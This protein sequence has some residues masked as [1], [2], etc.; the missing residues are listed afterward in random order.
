MDRIRRICLAGAVLALAATAIGAPVSALTI[1]P[2]LAIVQ[3]FPGS[4]VDI[5]LNGKEVR[6]RMRYGKKLLL[7]PN[8][9]TYKLKVFKHDPRKCKGT[10]IAQRTFTLGSE[11]DLSIVVGPGRPRVLIFDNALLPRIGGAADPTYIAWHQ[12]ARAP[13]ID[14]YVQFA[15]QVGPYTPTVGANAYARGD[16]YAVPATAGA[17]W[18]I[19]ATLDEKTKVIAGP[20]VIDVQANR[21]Y[22]QFLIGT[23]L[24]NYRIVTFSR[25]NYFN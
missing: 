9:G 21:R 6:S 7:S 2:Q 15:A 18:V 5:C 14:F 8:E 22:E 4:R 12:A 25:P 24:R 1:P 10:K 11:G 17:Q 3:G 13:L 20:K 23:R 19:W 16:W